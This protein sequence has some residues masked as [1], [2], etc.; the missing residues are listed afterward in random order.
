MDE[1]PFKI[2]TNVEKVP[3]K[4]FIES[5][6]ISFFLECVLDMLSLTI[7]MLVKATIC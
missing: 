5:E 6:I 2:N 1:Y 7:Y 3:R 4:F